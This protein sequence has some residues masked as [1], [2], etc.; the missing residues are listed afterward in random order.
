MANKIWQYSSQYNLQNLNFH[1]SFS[2]QEIIKKHG[3]GVGAFNHGEGEMIMWDGVMYKIRFGQPTQIITSDDSQSQS[4]LIFSTIFTGSDRFKLQQNDI[5]WHYDTLINKIQQLFVNKENDLKAVYCLKTRVSVK[6]IVLR[7]FN[8]NALASK[9]YTEFLSKQPTIE[10][11]NLNGY[12]V[13][14][15]PNPALMTLITSTPHLH[16]ISEDFNIGGH[17]MALTINNLEGE[18]IAANNLAVQLNGAI[19]F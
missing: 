12:I 14:I 16:F 7:C 17:V 2:P 18:I 5:N 15:L 3:Y 4:R 11:H 19:N 9:N 13:G 10:H 6:H 8:G 1:Q